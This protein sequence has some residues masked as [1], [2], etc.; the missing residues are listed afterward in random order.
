MPE[1]KDTGDAA[2]ERLRQIMARWPKPSDGQG[3]MP[4]AL[5]DGM[6]PLVPIAEMVLKLKVGYGKGYYAGAGYLSGSPKVTEADLELARAVLRDVRTDLPDAV[7]AETLLPRALY[8][9]IKERAYKFLNLAT[10]LDVTAVRLAKVGTAAG[11]AWDTWVSL[12]P[13]RDLPAAAAAFGAAKAPTPM[14]QKAEACVQRTRAFVNSFPKPGQGQ[15]VKASYVLQA[16]ILLQPLA[17]RIA[18]LKVGTAKGSIAGPGTLDAVLRIA[19]PWFLAV[20]AIE[21]RATP[22]TGYLS[23]SPKVTA[24]DIGVAQA[25]LGWIAGLPVFGP[26]ALDHGQYEAIKQLA[27]KLLAIATDLDI[28]TTLADKVTLFW[29][30]VSE[31]VADLRA[32]GE[33]GFNFAKTLTVI[34]AVVA[35]VY[36]G[37]TVL[38][39]RG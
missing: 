24:E 16:L 33:A 2:L 15:G 22:A 36:V 11:A 12:A 30:S 7:K 13:V 32:A 6:K 18:K 8:A 31:A 34:A 10:D 27:H 29:Q 9:K 5:L 20:E 35:G 25:L 21:G 37:K 23:G 3:V 19:F 4:Q 14:E 1:A 28:D 38:G 17:E 26:G 39:S